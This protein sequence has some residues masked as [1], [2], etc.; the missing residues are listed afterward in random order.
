MVNKLTI[1]LLRCGGRQLGS[2]VRSFIHSFVVLRGVL[3]KFQD[4]H[5]AGGG[6]WQNSRIPCSRE[7]LYTLEA[8]AAQRGRGR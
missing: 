6:K 2:F 3:L 7:P 5:L 8:A 1:I 4:P